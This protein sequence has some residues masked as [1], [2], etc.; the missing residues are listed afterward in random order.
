MFKYIVNKLNDR[1]GEL[2][3]TGETLLSLD[4]PQTWVIAAVLGCKY[5]DEFMLHIPKHV[6]YVGY[7]CRSVT[8]W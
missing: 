4:S 1:S 8:D 7:V 2:S 6:F 3:Q 5:V